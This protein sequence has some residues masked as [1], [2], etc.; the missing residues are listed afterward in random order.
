M[1]LTGLFIRSPGLK[2]FHCQI[3]SI[4]KTNCMRTPINSHNKKE[5]Q[6]FKKHS[7]GMRGGDSEGSPMGSRGDNERARQYFERGGSRTNKKF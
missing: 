3:L 4:Y 7:G 6:N 5:N 2:T 1:N